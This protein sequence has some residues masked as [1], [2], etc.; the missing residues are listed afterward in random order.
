MSLSAVDEYPVGWH[1]HA[2]MDIMTY[3]VEGVGR[4]ADSLGNRG[5]FAAPGM[6]WMSA[7]SGVEHAE[8]GGTPVNMVMH[9]FQIWV[10]V[11]MAR[12]FDTPKYGTANSTDTPENLPTVGLGE[13]VKAI[14]LAGSVG[15]S[16]HGPFRTVQSVHMLDVTVEAGA[17]MVH[18]IPENHNSALIYVYKGSALIAGQ[19]VQKREVALLDASDPSLRDVDLRAS[20]DGARFMLFTGQRVLEPIAWHGPIVMSS[21]VP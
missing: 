16:K 9:G 6:Q 18:K 1:P 17:R 11:P 14:V 5:T 2:G 10:N 20:D 7:G 21:Q 8:G 15:G 19:T 13:G 4:H 3:L 12:K